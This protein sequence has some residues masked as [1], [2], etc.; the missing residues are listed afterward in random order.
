MQTVNFSVKITPDGRTSGDNALGVSHVGISILVDDVAL[1]VIDRHLT[2]V[3]YRVFKDY[4][5][6]SPTGL[7]QSINRKQLTIE[8]VAKLDTFF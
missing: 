2:E 4:G 1:L 8:A 3:D 5:N 7:C 6:L